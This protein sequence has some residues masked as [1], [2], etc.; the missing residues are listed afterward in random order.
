MCLP[1]FQDEKMNINTRPPSRSELDF[2][3]R[4]Q[5]PGYAADDGNVV[6]APIPMTGVNFDA[7]GQNEAARQFMRAQNFSENQLPVLSDSQRDALS[8]TSYSDASPIDR[9]STILA[10]IFS[11]DPSGGTPTPEQR[12]FIENNLRGR[13]NFPGK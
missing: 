5:V 10:R 3:V 6:F 1:F 2:F 11:G 13:F 7:V 12:N 4:S 9:R 8:G